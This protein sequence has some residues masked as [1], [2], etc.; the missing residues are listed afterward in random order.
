MIGVVITGHG[1]FPEGLLSTAK[2]IIGDLENVIVVATRL[3]KNH[4]IYVQD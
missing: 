2:R 4:S 1:E 3:M